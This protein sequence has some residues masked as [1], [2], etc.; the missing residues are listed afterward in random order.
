MTKALDIEIQKSQTFLIS[1]APSS[2]P[3]F[4]D[5]HVYAE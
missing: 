2:P 1:S 5:F 4:K 3:C